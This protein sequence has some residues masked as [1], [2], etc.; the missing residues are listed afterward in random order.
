MNM[1]Y[2][3]I[4]LMGHTVSIVIPNWN[5]EHL[6]KKYLKDVIGAA[7]GAEIIV[8]DDASIDSSVSYL[9]DEYP[10]ITVVESR[11]RGGFA[12]NVNKGV[13]GAKGDIVV[14]LNTDVKPEKGFLIPL[15]EHFSDAQVFAVGSLEKSEEEARTLLRGRGLAR[16]RK[17]YY[18]HS[19]GEVNKYDTAWV[20]GGSGAFR[21][22][23]WNKLGGM[24]TLYSPFY[25]EDI[26]ISY[27]ARK[28]GWKT[29]FEPKS[30]VHH[31]HEEG[32]IK[33]EYTPSDVNR[34][35]YRN[36]FIF[37]W[38]NVTDMSILFSHI[39][40]TPFRLI[41][42]LCSGDVIM[43]QGYILAL[44]RIPSIMVHRGRQSSAYIKHDKE[45]EILG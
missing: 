8:S 20:A 4:D 26:D 40:W 28:A 16:W 30:I 3:I 11:A 36:Q 37:I 27:R 6:L 14:L 31:Y 13:A 35:A 1:R 10:Q 38:K 34:I 5:G 18:I 2:C 12:Q 15:L 19:R 21:K 29:L 32:K 17:G 9:R 45:L 22:S 42:A 33:R 24:D 23:M 44:L 7:Q 43:F 39:F 25:W 41:R